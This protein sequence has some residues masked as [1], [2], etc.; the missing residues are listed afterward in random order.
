M[1]LTLNEILAIVEADFLREVWRVVA[2]VSLHL[3]TF[4]ALAWLFKVTG[5]CGKILKAYRTHPFALAFSIPLIVYGATKI[6]ILVP[7]NEQCDYRTVEEVDVTDGLIG[8]IRFTGETT[9]TNILVACCGNAVTNELTFTHAGQFYIE[10]DQYANIDLRTN[11]FWVRD[12]ETNDWIKATADIY[13]RE[14]TRAVWLSGWSSEIAHLPNYADPKDYRY[15]FVGPEEKLPEKV[16]EGGVGIEI[17]QYYRDAHKIHIEFH[18]NDPELNGA[19]FVLQCR[20]V[21]MIDGVEVLGDWKTIATT[22]TN[23]F[24]VQGNFIQTYNQLRIY[25]DKEGKE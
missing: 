17:D 12:S 25:A 11:P 15:W 24:D 7:T 22:T 10:T 16:I 19:T 5:V 23:I 21:T 14:I 3:V 4:F 8:Y 20:T 9:P 18:S 2:I 6:V 1:E 13:G